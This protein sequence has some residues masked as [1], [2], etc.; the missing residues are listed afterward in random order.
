MLREVTI[1]FRS[2]LADRLVQQD[3]DSRI[4]GTRLTGCARY[5]ESG[6]TAA[7]KIHCAAGYRRLYKLASFHPFLPSKR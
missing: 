2:Y 5:C 7:G 3:L 6:N 1:D 4:G